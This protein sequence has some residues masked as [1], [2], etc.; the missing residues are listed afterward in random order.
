MSKLDQSIFLLISMTQMK[1]LYNSVSQIFLRLKHKEID[2][3]CHWTNSLWVKNLFKFV[4]SDCKLQNQYILCSG[5]FLRGVAGSKCQGIPLSSLLSGWS[6]WDLG[7]TTEFAILFSTYSPPPVAMTASKAD[8]NRPKII[9]H[10]VAKAEK[11]FKYNIGIRLWAKRAI[12]SKDEEQNFQ[13]YLAPTCC[14]S[15]ANSRNEVY[16]TITQ[17][18]LQTNQVVASRCINCVIQRP[19]LYQI[20][21]K[22][23]GQKISNTSLAFIIFS[24]DMSWK[25][26][27]FKVTR[28]WLLAL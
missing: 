12:G 22:W 20:L 11:R 24:N 28:S 21:G 17:V 8:P 9:N 14:H 15:T 16:I 27:S 5:I 7:F 6:H 2:L 4:H 25:V 13:F 23:W 3:I 19:T 10:K 1:I 18:R 26:K